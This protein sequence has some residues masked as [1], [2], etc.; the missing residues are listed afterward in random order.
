VGAE[1]RRAPGGA[2]GERSPSVAVHV[3]LHVRDATREDAASLGRGA[4]ERIEA[5]GTPP[6]GLMFL[7]VHPDGDGFR[8]T[9][10]CRTEDAA[11]ALVDGLLRE[12]AA[13]AGLELGEPVVSP[14]WDMALPGAR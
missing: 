13:P 7:C 2:R 4:E 5:A 3:E 1:A 12:V 10:V 9:M 6:D 11:R 8:L 14:V